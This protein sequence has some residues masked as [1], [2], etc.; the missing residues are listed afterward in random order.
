MY[1]RREFNMDD[2]IVEAYA[3]GTALGVY[4]FYVNGQKVGPYRLAP[5]WTSYHKHL[6]YQTYDLTAFLHSG[7][8]CFG[9][10]VGA[11]WYKG[12]M[13]FTL[14]RNHYG[15]RA[16]F[17]CQF[18]VRMR[19]GE[20]ICI[21]TDENYLQRLPELFFRKFMMARPMTLKKEI[22]GWST[23]ECRTGMWR[24]VELLRMMRRC[25]HSRAHA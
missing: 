23:P 10:L 11:G 7:R 25:I 9:A 3:Y 2:E 15:D 12:K 6:L 8:N 4:E 22:P 24:P 17:R 21:G 13:G 18:S 1:L 16:A 14:D 5:G 20:T 19:S